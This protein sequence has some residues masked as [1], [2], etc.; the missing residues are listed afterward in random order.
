MLIELKGSDE[1]LVHQCPP[2]KGRPVV[3]LHDVHSYMLID[4]MHNPVKYC[5]YCGVIVCEDYSSQNVF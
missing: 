5:P 3:Y 4:G 1:T 2:G